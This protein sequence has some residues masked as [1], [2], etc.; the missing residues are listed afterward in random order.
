MC[1]FSRI[2]LSI[3]LAMNSKIPLVLFNSLGRI[4]QTFAP[5]KPGTVQ[6]YS[7]GPTVY[8]YAHIGNLR[9]YVFT[10]TLRRALQWKGY[11]VFHVMNITDV[12]HLTSDADEGEDKVERAAQ[13]ENKSIWEIAAFYTQQFQ[14]DLQLLNIQSPALW[15]KATD[16]IQE[17]I[18]FASACEQKGYT[19]V[20]EDGLYFDTTKVKNYGELALLNISGQEEGSRVTITSGKRNPSDFALWRCSPKNT[21]RLMEWHSPWGLGA[22]GWHLECSAM[23]IKYLGQKFDIHTGGIDHRQIH[24]CNEIAQN[25]AFLGNNSA[26]ANF[27]LHNEFLNMKNQKM[28]KSTGQFV[29]LQ[30]LIDLGIHPLVFRYFCL[31]ATYRT[32]LDFTM[33]AI[34]AARSGLMRLLKRIDVL[35]KQ[36]KNLQWL[37]VLDDVKYSNGAALTFIRGHVE[38]ELSNDCMKFIEKFDAAISDD[39][40]VPQALALLSAVIADSNIAPDNVLRLVAGF[41]L[42]FG[43]QLLKLSPQDLNIRP[44]ETKIEESEILELIN[45]R[46]V[47]REANNFKTADEIRNNLLSKGVM[48]MDSNE[49]SSWEWLVRSYDDDKNKGS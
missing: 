26:A 9:A 31:I 43:L 39:L 32:P 27:W 41:D 2:S 36:S 28:S 42:V 22:P 8:H 21:K 1:W 23:S 20:L 48:V 16:H 45:K 30:S 15:T 40:N 11:D 5:I 34:A 12:G 25:Q 38:S 3:L 18:N 24:H 14:H 33:E 17:M 49:G 46:R 4:V 37:A 29:R 13:R 19:Y 35:K 7:C 6:L 10:D 47:A 44:E